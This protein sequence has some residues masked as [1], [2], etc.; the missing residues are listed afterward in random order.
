MRCQTE[1]FKPVSE[2]LATGWKQIQKCAKVPETVW[3]KKGPI[4]SSQSWISS[5][6]IPLGN[7]KRL[8]CI[9]SRGHDARVTFKDDTEGLL[10]QR[11]QPTALELGTCVP[12]CSM[13]RSSILAEGSSAVPHYPTTPLIYHGLHINTTLLRKL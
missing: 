4:I 13:L 8:R 6:Q 5:L 2:V 10:Y 7:V 1:R 11:L 12:F 3:P 9:T